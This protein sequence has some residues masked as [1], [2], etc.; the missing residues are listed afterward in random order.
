MNENEIW[1][2]VVDFED[3]YQV[4][5]LGRVRSK[6]R[7]VKVTRSNGIIYERIMKPKIMKDRKNNCGYHQ[8][9]LSDSF[10]EQHDELVHRLVAKAFIPN[11]DPE[12]VTVNH[13]NGNKDNNTVSNLEWM[14]YSEQNQH[15][16]D[17]GLKD[18]TKLMKPLSEETKKKMSE[19]RKGKINESQCKK[20]QQIDPNTDKV[21]NVFNSLAEAKK[22]VNA[23]DG[24]GISEAARGINNRKTA[25]GYKWKF[26]E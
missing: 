2:D 21:I 23:K 24:K 1:K 25:Y 11:S 9:S 7:T 10:G 22:A 16:Y 3:F 4:S 13:K 14:T 15:A 18:K 19:S 8:I 5:N 6:E 17:T 12:K 20:I 26:D